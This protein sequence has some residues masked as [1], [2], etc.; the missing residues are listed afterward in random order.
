MAEGCFERCGR[1]TATV[2]HLWET[3][4][5]H[6]IFGGYIRDQLKCPSCGFCRDKYEAFLDL[7][8]PL[9]LAAMVDEECSLKEVLEHFT[10]V[11]VM[12]DGNRW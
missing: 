11:E 3:T 7:S 2:G 9:P 8:L 1:D 4:A 5:V 6:R 10:T 12:G